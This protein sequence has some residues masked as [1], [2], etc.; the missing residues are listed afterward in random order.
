MTLAA[1]CGKKAHFKFKECNL[2]KINCIQNNSLA[3]PGPPHESMEGDEKTFDMIN[4]LANDIYCPEEIKNS[5]IRYKNT[6][7]INI[8]HDSSSTSI[9]KRY[10]S[11]TTVGDLKKN[12]EKILETKVSKMVLENRTN[13]G[14][15]I[16]TLKPNEKILSDFNL[17]N[18]SNIHCL[19]IVA[20]DGSAEVL[21]EEN[22]QKK[23]HKRKYKF[24]MSDRIQMKIKKHS[25]S[26]K[27]PHKG[28]I[29]YIGKCEFDMDGAWIGIAFDKPVGKHAGTVNGIHYFKC[30]DKHGMFLRTKK[31][32]V[33]DCPKIK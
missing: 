18:F 28:K 21:S 2:C 4:I 22:I 15:I 13:L 29:K 33:D 30:L 19:N 10:P 24:N 27:I 11:T 23:R 20:D 26:N 3:E 16:C 8:T 6:I 5:L 1:E 12:L 17:K 32:E 9:K 14:E 31:I 7:R 25:N